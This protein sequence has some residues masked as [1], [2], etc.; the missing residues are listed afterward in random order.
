MFENVTNDPYSWLN[1]INNNNINS[2]YVYLDGYCFD[3]Y[4]VS[5]YFH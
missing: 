3:S 5:G 2:F 1:N 4:S